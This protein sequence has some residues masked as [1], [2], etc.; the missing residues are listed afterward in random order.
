MIFRA[1]RPHE[2]HEPV[3]PARG[4]WA[5]ARGRALRRGARSGGAG[6]P[7]GGTMTPR[8]ELA[9]G[10]P[11]RPTRG[12]DGAVDPC[13]ATKSEPKAGRHGPTSKARTRRRKNRRTARRKAPRGPLR[14]ARTEGQAAPDGARVPA[15][16]I[17]AAARSA[18]GRWCR[19]RPAAA[20]RCWCK[21]DLPAAARKR[22]APRR[23]KRLPLT[24]TGWRRSPA[25]WRRS[26]DEGARWRIPPRRYGA[27]TVTLKASAEQ[28]FSAPLLPQTSKI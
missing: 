21:R 3:A 16:A 25:L 5:G 24:K 12:A 27:L 1:A 14:S 9:D 19:R 17:R 15:G 22:F 13:G 20:S 26:G 8:E 6:A 7:P 4:G 18:T 11:P 23:P 2:G 10:G 28:P